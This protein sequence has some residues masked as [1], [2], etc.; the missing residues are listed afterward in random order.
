MIEQWKKIKGYSNYKISSTGRVMSNSLIRKQCLGKRGY[1]VI[2]LYENNIRKNYKVHRLVANAFIKNKDNKLTVN[3]I[4]GNKLNNSVENLEW[5]TYKENNNHAIK[6][7]LM[8]KDR[9]INLLKAKEIRSLADIKS[10][11]ELSSMFG[12]TKATICRVIRNIIW[13]EVN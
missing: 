5:A 4:D 8:I 6:N 11:E 9:K 12:V 2:D 13:K 7:G 1:L 3:H 10:R